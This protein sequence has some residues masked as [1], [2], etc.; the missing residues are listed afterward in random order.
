MRT[1]IVLESLTGESLDIELE[2]DREHR[3]VILHML[4]FDAELVT[5]FVTKGLPG[6]YGAALKEGRRLAV[7]LGGRFH[8]VRF[9]HRDGGGVELRLGDSDGGFLAICSTTIGTLLS[10]LAARD[11]EAIVVGVDRFG[12]PKPSE[13]NTLYV[14]TRHLN[15]AQEDYVMHHCVQLGLQQGIVF[16]YTRFCREYGDTDEVFPRVPHFSWDPV[17]QRVVTRNWSSECAC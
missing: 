8:P 3:L 7:S 9:R 17:L 13:R 1:R 10:T 12:R 6:E 5:A 14:F 11:I 2:L 16:W 15:E 4:E